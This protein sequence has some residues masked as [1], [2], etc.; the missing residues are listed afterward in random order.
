MARADSVAMERFI[1]D[2]EKDP[3]PYQANRRL[4]A[5]SS[6]L[7]ESAWM[8]AFT[9][10]SRERGFSY[11]VLSQGGSQRIRSRALE[12]VLK[13]EK[14]NTAQWR[15]AALT[16]ENYAF[17]CGGRG[18]DGL[19]KI[20]LNPRRRDSRLFDG[21]V[22]VAPQSGR[23]VRLE[24]SL[25]KSPSFWIRWVSVTRRYEPI[26]GTMMPAS[27][28]S[29]A[30][31]RIAGVSTFSMTYEYVAVNGQAIPLSPRILASR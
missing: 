8:E 15:K 25:S 6:K 1:N 13:A 22:W 16:R 12:G 27:V 30:D 7:G 26:L 17:E 24:G 29:T 9:E 21:A 31:V 3:I 14:D 4:E 18:S 5:S 20:Q 19:L 10:Y 28:E 2:I 23:L 11:R